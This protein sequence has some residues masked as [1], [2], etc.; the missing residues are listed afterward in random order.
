MTSIGLCGNSG[1]ALSEQDG[2]LSID[3]NGESAL[4]RN[5][6]EYT[7]A[8]FPEPMVWLMG[9]DIPRSC[10]KIAPIEMEQFADLYRQVI[11]QINAH[12]EEAGWPEIIYQPI[13]EPFEHSKHMARAT[14]LL[15][16]LKS[17]PGVRTEEDGMNGRWENFT[18]E[19]YELTDVLVLHDG[20]TLHRGRLDM[21][22][23]WQFH[24]KAMTDGKTIWFYNIDLT[25]WH[26]EPMRFMGG[27]G[28][29]KSKATGVIE[30]A[31]MFPVK[32][33]KPEA[34]YSQPRALLFRFAKAPGESGGPTIGYEA[35]REGIDDY[36]Y[37][38]TLKQFVEKAHPPVGG[39][40]SPDLTRLADDIWAPIQAKLDAAS[41][42][43]CKGRAGQGN[44]TGECEF[45]P[46]GNRAA[47]GDHKIANNWEFE[48]YDGLRQQIA[49]GVV[50]LQEAMRR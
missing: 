42:D 5:M 46:D 18:D 1:L 13:D 25:A 30:W 15:E 23:W 3:W 10:E 27:F 24:E 44:W 28:L 48:D 41:F 20:P 37:L 26:P 35:F 7:R 32:E 39:A 21:D 43:G 22:E 19:A 17:I 31:Y 50:R 33:D 2:K 4:E 38:L 47:R 16:V 11:M 29:W 9:A 40:S 6:D 12:G 14:R 49:E 8:G 36:R 45:L 34:V